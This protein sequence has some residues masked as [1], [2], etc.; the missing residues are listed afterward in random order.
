MSIE[1]MKQALEALYATETWLS[2]GCETGFQN[3][4]TPAISRLEQAIAE[5]E[6]QP[7]DLTI[8]YMSGYHDG[9]KAQPK[10]WVRLNWDDLPEIYVGDKAFMHGA[11]W[12]EA[13]LKEKN[14]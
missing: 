12:A 5:A 14:Q 9:K 1:T 3:K 11:Q 10:Q 6:K 4:I 8:A 2:S 7:N 13:K